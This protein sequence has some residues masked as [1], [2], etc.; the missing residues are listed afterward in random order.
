M[1]ISATV[2]EPDTRTLSTPAAPVPPRAALALASTL[3]SFSF[4]SAFRTTE[5]FSLRIVVPSF[6]VTFA[7]VPFTV[8]FSVPPAA[9]LLPDTA[10]LAAI[11]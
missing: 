2:F 7:S 1:P 10:A 9:V 6:T 5:P 8:T 11:R 3:I 4:V